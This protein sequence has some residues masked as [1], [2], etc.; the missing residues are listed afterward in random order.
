M[1]L[2]VCRFAIFS[3]VYA[4]VTLCWASREGG[5]GAMGIVAGGIIFAG[6]AAVAWSV[7][8]II[9]RLLHHT[10]MGWVT[11][12]CSVIIIFHLLSLLV[13][14]VLGGLGAAGTFDFTFTGI[15]AIAAMADGAVG[16]WFDRPKVE[17]HG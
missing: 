1:L 12:T 15:V 14:L 6:G 10:V 2:Y 11:H 3:A 4:G 13:L 5:H 16:A 17:Q 7:G 9:S 8:A